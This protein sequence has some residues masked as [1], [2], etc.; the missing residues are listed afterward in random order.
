[1]ASSIR[2]CFTILN[3]RSVIDE[4]AEKPQDAFV[5]QCP[6]IQATIGETT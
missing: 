4:Q 2:L 5:R 6:F 1:M 3:Q